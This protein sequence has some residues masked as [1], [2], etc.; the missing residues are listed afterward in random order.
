M[1]YTYSATSAPWYTIK[2]ASE[3]EI[4]AG[5]KALG[6]PAS[7]VIAIVYDVTSSKFVA[8]IHK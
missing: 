8:F 7:N 6:I 4:V 5:L 3:A 1:A 2:D